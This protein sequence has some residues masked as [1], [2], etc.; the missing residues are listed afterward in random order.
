MAGALRPVVILMVLASALFV[1]DGWLDGAYPGGHGWF[2]G[3][4]HGGMAWLAYVFAAI[5]AAFAIV[6]A[7]GSQ[8]TLIIRIGLSAF[9]LAE[10]PI[11]AFALPTVSSEAVL[12]HLATAFLELVILLGGVRV[13]RL[14]MS[15][16]E[17]DLDSAFA[18]DAP[19]PSPRYDADESAPP[20]RARSSRTIGVLALL[21]AGV[22]A[23]HGL[24]AGY[25]PGGRAWGLGSDDRGWIVYLFAAVVLTA[26]LP[27]MRGG[28]LALR[29]LFALGLILFLE[30][31]LTPLLSRS[32]DER[33]L[34]L[35]ALGTFLAL[36]V[37]LSSAAAI[38][39]HARA[40]S[41]VASASTGSA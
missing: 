39:T 38:R 35:H 40:P 9:F 20:I 11:T 5:N 41:R 10:R 12:V 36:A 31:A 29:T 4:A 37:A 28:R 3:E 19:S 22:L 26:A 15:V 34:A 16:A 30:R 24:I 2:G 1:Y 23:A 33:S 13:W 14:G 8:R 21:L 17:G 25:V 18:L 6:I 27:A 7:R 32:L